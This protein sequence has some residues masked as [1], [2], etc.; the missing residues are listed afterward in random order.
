[1][2][3][4]VLSVENDNNFRSRCEWIFRHFGSL[5][6]SYFFKFFEKRKMKKIEGKKSWCT[7]TPRPIIFLRRGLVN[8]EIQEQWTTY[9]DVWSALVV[10][11]LNEFLQFTCVCMW[12]TSIRNLTLSVHTILVD[13]RVDNLGN[14]WP[15]TGDGENKSREVHWESWTCNG[16]VRTLSLGV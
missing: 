15:K 3:L 8:K 2:V 14:T 4:I 12:H 13:S 6:K 1:M 7:N 16:I 9:T 5:V 10:S 11:R